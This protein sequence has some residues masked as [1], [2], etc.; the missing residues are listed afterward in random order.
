MQSVSQGTADGA[1]A[2]LLQ[3]VPKNDPSVDH[4]V[5]GVTA[6]GY[7]PVSAQ[8]FYKD[9]STI[10]LTLQNQQVQS[11]TL[12]QS[13]TISVAMPKYNLDATAT[14]GTYA[15]NAEVPDSVFQSN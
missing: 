5:F 8:W 10:R 14:Y 7:Q 13:E 4:V 9:G 3:A 1:T 2:Y 11:F 15:I 12:P 6:A